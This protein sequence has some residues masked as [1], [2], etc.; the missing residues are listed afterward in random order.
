MTEE[1]RTKYN[2]GAKLRMRRYRERK[3]SQNNNCKMRTRSEKEKL[4]EVWRLAKRRQREKLTAQG[5]RRYN[6]KR[7]NWYKKNKAKKALKFES[8][9]KN[10]ESQLD[11]SI[12][13][14]TPNTKDRLEGKGFIL[15]PR[16]MKCAAT[17]KKIVLSL[18]EKLKELKSNRS[19]IG[20]QKY[21]IFVKNIA[22][23][24]YKDTQMRKRLEIKHHF[25]E[26]AT[27]AMF[28]EELP[29]SDSM[30]EKLKEKITSYYYNNS[31]NLPCK[32]TVINQQQKCVLNR[33]VKDLHKIY[34]AESGHKVS[35]N[36]FRK[37]RPLNC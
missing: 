17:D 3:K 9:K 36:A 21:Q 24:S 7:R 22:H 26:W 8:P 6:E 34:L 16:S 31:D 23:K 32:S 29:R 11:A 13:M 37:L 5:L 12:H 4:R 14:A 30:D 27:N 33:T 10:I 25:W 19:K 2:E 28:E 20:R 15:S 1:K 18:K 35:L